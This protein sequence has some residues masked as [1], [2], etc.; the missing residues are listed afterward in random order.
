[1]RRPNHL[2]PLDIRFLQEA[3]ERS[4]GIGLGSNQRGNQRHD[5][6]PN[7]PHRGDDQVLEPIVST[8]ACN[9]QRGCQRQQ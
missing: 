1:M 9:Q 4:S 5:D 3:E 8:D 6:Q 7:H 2:A